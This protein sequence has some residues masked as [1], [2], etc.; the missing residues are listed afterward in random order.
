MPATECLFV[1][2]HPVND[3]QGARQVGMQT[4][5]LSGFHASKDIEIEH[6]IENLTQVLSFLHLQHV[7]SFATN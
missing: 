3:I 5:W 4:L 2:D 1:G 6:K 7:N